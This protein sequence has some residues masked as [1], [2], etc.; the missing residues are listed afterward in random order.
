MPYFLNGWNN[1]KNNI[2]WQVKIIHEI[3]ISVSIKF[4]WNIATSVPLCICL[5]L[6]SHFT[7]SRAIAAETARGR[8][9][10]RYWQSLQKKFADFCRNA[11][12]RVVEWGLLGSNPLYDSSE[13]TLSVTIDQTVKLIN[14]RNCKTNHNSLWFS[15]SI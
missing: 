10:L 3:Q 1:L 14:Y 2:L 5:R 4:Y 9:S 6:Q 15:D 7:G 12:A 11:L 8:Q 13:E